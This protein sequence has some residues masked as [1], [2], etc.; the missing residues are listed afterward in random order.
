MNSTVSTL[1]EEEIRA[2]LEREEGQFLEFKSLWDRSGLVS[3]VLDRRKVRDW[4]AEYVSAFANA[5]GGT[6]I[7]GDEDDGTPSGHSY[8][9][10]AVENFFRVPET[11]LQPPVACR[12]ARVRIDGK[13]ILLFEVPSAA[14]AVMVEG[15]G[16]PYRTRDQLVREAQEVI[17][18]LKE[19]GRQVGFEKRCPQDAT[20]KDLDLE[21]VSRFFKG[22]PLGGRKPEE[23][24]AN[25]SLIQGKAGGWGITN[26]AL[27][28]FAKGPVARWHPNMGIRFFR[29]QGTERLH[30]GKRNVTQGPRVELPLAAAIQEAH[31]VARGQIGRSEKLHDLFF[32]ETPEYPDFAWQEAIVNAVAH[33]DYAVQGLGIEVWFYTDRMEVVSPGDLIPPATLEGLRRK[34]PVHASRNP[35]IVRVLAEGR[36]MRDEGEGIPRIFEEMEESF[37]R[38][39]A[40]DCSR[41]MFKV[42][43]YNEPIFS[44]PSLEWQ[45]LVGN[46]PLTGEQKK[47]LL[48][49][50]EGFTNGDFQKLNGVDRDEAYRQI[51][52]LVS[53]GVLSSSQKR[54]RGAVYR[55]ASDLRQARA[56]LEAR[57]PEL[58]RFFRT[59]RLLKNADYRALFHLSRYAAS[60]ELKRLVEE[61]FLRLEGEKRGAHYLPQP[62]LE[63]AQK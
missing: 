40:F 27:L 20:L 55:V 9:D 21:L 38:P 62:S 44:G 13:E 48:A 42:T 15:D 46:L 51:Q 2:L 1:N 25:F 45:K 43:L 26:A 10:E 28:L 32:R 34:E 19:S 53:V 8:P 5:E 58:R 31:K 6:I 12:K 47:V 61:G 11:R 60:R 14:Q 7:L 56:F 18:H 23:L 37:L 24:L 57:V 17:N 4:I 59:N 29:V 49:H 54:G 16:F 41:G 30:G 63:G 50:P 3:K 22:T 33:R 39:P 52:E 36:I 35:L